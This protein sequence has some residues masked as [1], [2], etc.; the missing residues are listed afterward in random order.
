MS[1]Q[2]NPVTRFDC[3]WCGNRKHAIQYRGLITM[4]PSEKTTV[5]AERAAVCLVCP[6]CDSPGATVR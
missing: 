4:H 5:H 2:P 3:Q 6:R 1:K